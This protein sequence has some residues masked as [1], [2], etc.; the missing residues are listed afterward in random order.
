MA[1]AE[2]ASIRFSW[3]SRATY[4]CFND[5]SSS[6]ASRVSK[7]EFSSTAMGFPLGSM[8]TLVTIP[9]TLERRSWVRSASTRTFPGT[10]SRTVPITTGFTITSGIALTINHQP[11]MDNAPKGRATLSKSFMEYEQGTIPGKK[12]IK[13][14]NLQFVKD[15]LLMSFF[16]VPVELRS[17]V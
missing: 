7:V 12:T 15:W 11:R 5:R 14:A 1:I 2:P 4:S 10:P 8:L 13:A 3:C 6:V 17:Y 9:E 16:H